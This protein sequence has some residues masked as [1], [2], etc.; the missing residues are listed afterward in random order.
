MHLSENGIK[1]HFKRVI[2]PGEGVWW[3][4]E[5]DCA[6]FLDGA[7]ELS[8]NAEGPLMM[9][10]ESKTLSD[11]SSYLEEQ[12]AKTINRKSLTD[13]PILETGKLKILAIFKLLFW[14]IINVWLKIFNGNNKEII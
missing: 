10:F 12:W 3:K 14:Y 9:T 8:V 7:D 6:I 11:V 1:S 4:R 2:S 13:L 5:G